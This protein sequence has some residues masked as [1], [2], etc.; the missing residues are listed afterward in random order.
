MHAENLPAATGRDQ[1]TDAM[2]L[3][4]QASKW[5]TCP[6]GDKAVAAISQLRKPTRLSKE[7]RAITCAHYA[8]T[9][10]TTIPQKHTMLFCAMLC[11]TILCAACHTAST[12]SMQWQSKA[13]NCSSETVNYT[14]QCVHTLLPCCLQSS[15]PCLTVCQMLAVGNLPSCRYSLISCEC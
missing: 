7:V 13:V 11:C 8:V 1:T 6:S 10:S 3:G 5:T 2:L 15:P 14:S 9:Y 4:C 12:C